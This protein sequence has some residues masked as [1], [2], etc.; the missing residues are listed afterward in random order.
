M[1]KLKYAI[2]FL[3]AGLVTASAAD[4]AWHLLIEPSFMHYESSWP[5]AGAERT[6]LVPARFV[7]DQILPLRE[8]EAA[9][10]GATRE[11]ILESASKAASAVLAGLKPRF[12]RDDHNVIQCAVLESDNPLT[13]SAVLAPEFSALFDE[14]LGPDILVAIPN[15]FRVFVFPKNAP[16]FQRYSEVVIAEYESSSCPV[17]KELFSLRKGKLAA[18]GSYR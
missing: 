8:G 1:R 18:V 12:I 15:R 7:D 4:E 14:S 3:M 11:K 5:I 6:V 10:L 2:G 13:A 16:A 9:S 17:S